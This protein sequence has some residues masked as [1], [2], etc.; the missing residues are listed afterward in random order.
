M[1]R[2]VV[3]DTETTGLDASDG[4]RI[5]EIAAVEVSGRRLTGNHF[6]RYLNP[7]RPI[8]EGAEAV[9]GISAEFLADK[10]RFADVVEDMLRF[11]SGAQLVIHNAPFDVS[12]LNAE[13]ARLERGTIEAVCPIT[14]TLAMARRLHPG[15]KNSLDALCERYQVDNSSRVLHGALLDAELL[16]DVYLAMTRGQDSLDITAG[17]TPAAIARRAVA[18]P[19]KLKVIRATP[20]E[21]ALHEKLVVGLDKASGGKAVWRRYTAEVSGDAATVSAPQ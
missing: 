2:I 14:D 11:V 20:E 19:A 1:D 16:A 18:R 15:K 7:E 9:H 5:I 21:S 12:F 3:L 17:E 8:D 6:H 4:H 10:P 13:L